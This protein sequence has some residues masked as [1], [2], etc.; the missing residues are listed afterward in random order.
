MPGVYFGSPEPEQLSGKVSQGVSASPFVPVGLQ[1]L[2]KSASGCWAL[3]CSFDRRAPGGEPG[4]NHANQ[5][6]MWNPGSG[7][8]A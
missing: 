3:D 6:K 4:R 8:G 1:K 5:G 2:Q 7:L